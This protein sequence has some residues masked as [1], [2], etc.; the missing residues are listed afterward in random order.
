L[1]K[2]GHGRSEASSCPASPVPS[3][4]VPAVASR[5]QSEASR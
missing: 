1:V 2:A 3:A 4:S 5:A